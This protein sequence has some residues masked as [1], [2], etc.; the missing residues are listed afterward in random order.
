VASRQSALVKLE[1]PPLIGN[2]AQPVE[3]ADG[4]IIEIDENEFTKGFAA[5][6]REA[7]T[8][9]IEVSE[10]FRVFDCFQLAIE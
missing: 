5:D 7:A 10:I 2:G 9:E 6:P 1:L 4:G 8:A 3:Q